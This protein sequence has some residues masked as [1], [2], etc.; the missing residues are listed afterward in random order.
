[1]PPLNIPSGIITKFF[2][3]PCGRPKPV[4]PEQDNYPQLFVLNTIM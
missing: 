2:P 4:T 1:M 3:Y